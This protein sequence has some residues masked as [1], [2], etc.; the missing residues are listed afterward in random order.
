[1]PKHPAVVAML[2]TQ[3]QEPVLDRGRCPKCQASTLRMYAHGRKECRNCGHS[4][5]AR[6]SEP[7]A[8]PP[9]PV[10]EPEPEETP[11]EPE[12][13]AE[14]TTRPC[15]KCGQPLKPAG[16]MGR[17]RRCYDCNPVQRTSTKPSPETSPLPEARHD[18]AEAVPPPPVVRPKLEAQ[19]TVTSTIAPR[20]LQAFNACAAILEPM[21]DRERWQTLRALIGF[22]DQTDPLPC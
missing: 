21:P 11:E 4:V 17:G 1:M 13:K 12:A 18:E 2:A 3:E 22:Y 7:P 20:G 5:A 10:V 14:P 9:R 6:L 19:V 15:P 8:P 16:Y